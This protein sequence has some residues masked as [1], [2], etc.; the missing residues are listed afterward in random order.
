MRKII[1]KLNKKRALAIACLCVAAGIITA[2]CFAVS[3]SEDKLYVSDT[4]SSSSVAAESST[5]KTTTSSKSQSSAASTEAKSE[6]QSESVSSSSAESVGTVGEI[7]GSSGQS[8]EQSVASTQTVSSGTYQT[9]TDAQS[10]SENTT[11]AAVQ[12]TTSTPA[13]QTVNSYELSSSFIN[14]M[15][16]GMTDDERDV[17]YSILN[18]VANHETGVS[19]KSGVIRTDNTAALNNMFLVVKSALAYSDPLDSGYTFSGDRYVTHITLSYKLTQAEY[20]AQTLAAKAAID[21]IIAG[22][23][24]SVGDYEKALY[25]H[26][27]ILERCEYS[28]DDRNTV[29]S[30]YGCLVSGKASCEG[31]AKT[32]ML[33][34]EKA[35]LPCVTVTGKAVSGGESIA[36]MWNKVKVSGRWYNID[37]CWDDSADSSVYRYDYFLVNDSAIG[38]NH[39]AEVNEFYAYPDAAATGDN[40][41]VKNS[42]TVSKSTELYSKLESAFELAL[43]RDRTCAEIKLADSSLLEYAVKEL[44][45]DGT[46]I[47]AAFER[48]AKAKGV[49]VSAVSFSHS[50]N[51]AACTLL[52]TFKIS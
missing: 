44:S 50:V 9:I 32:Y 14:N 3:G 15:T 34:C 23:A 4:D 51:S 7:V 24:S 43:S 27:S 38:S 11:T 30:A 25:L 42:L 21:K 2:V 19:I 8:G 26:D 47:T 33:L 18:A 46:H 45:V 12:T 48:A 36:H 5:S 35:G 37:V 49:E 39:T 6:A 40:Y 17:L 31:Y 52:V 22:M 28:T 41:F 29:S 10:S 1:E 20:E 13:E 16:D